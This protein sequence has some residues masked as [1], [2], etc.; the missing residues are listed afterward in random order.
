MTVVILAAGEGRRLEPLTNRRPKPMIPVANRPLLE[1]VVEAVAEAGIDDIV[2]V[3]GYK[4]E[5]IQTYFGDGDDWGVDIE[6]VVQEKQLGTGHAILQAEPVVD[7][8]F[9]V[10]NGD[11]IVDTTLLDTLVGTC[12]PG[13]TDDADA[14]M[15]VTRTDQ[16][17]EYGVV[18]LDGDRVTSIT[19]KPRAEDS[20]TDIVNAG[21]YAFQTGIFDAIRA[22]PATDDGEQTITNTIAEMVADGRVRAM[23]YEGQWVDV[24]H[25]WD[26]IR[27]TADV[28]D[29]HGTDVHTTASVAPTAPL[30]DPVAVGATSRID[31][32]ATIGRGTAVGPNVTVGSGA[33]LSNAVVFADATV[34]PGAVLRNCVVGENASVGAN[35]T[36]AGGPADVIVEGTVYEDVALGAVIGDNA[37]VGGGVVVDGGT[38][39]GDDASVEDGAT[40]TGR[41]SPGTEVRRG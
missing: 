16:P 31:P 6:Y 15:A 33:V 20:P 10:L 11:G 12:R 39:I 5:R 9:L 38:V 34:G 26:V 24:S 22:T 2:L 1:S 19:E 7:G 14:V 30:A 36:A 41:V 28:L 13:E 40:I 35:V 17:S 29:G 25:L 27:V 23:R 21:A 8:E 3:V 4:R 37:R 18:E 32:N